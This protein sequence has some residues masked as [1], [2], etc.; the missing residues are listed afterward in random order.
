MNRF[1]RVNHAL[2]YPVFRVLFPFRATGLENLPTDR[3]FILCPN[4]AN[5]VDPIL[6]CLSL[7]GSVPIR[8][9]AKK[10][11]M[12]APVL[13]KFL[14]ALGV[15]GVDRGHSDIAALKT[16]M[17]TLRDGENLL[18]FPEGT[19]VKHEGEVEAKG[20]VAMLA[21]RTGAVLV[22]VYAGERKKLL[23]RTHI[24]FGAPYEPKTAGRRGTAEEY[25]AFAD[26]VLRRAYALGREAKP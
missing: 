13:G 1:Y 11:L 2:F 20:G 14:A 8:V 22:P 9:M 17:K 25:Q 21:L 26:E 24:V 16:A 12:D 7:S 18:V 10:E 15:F 6:I 19:R 23:H 3:V 5:A 4:H